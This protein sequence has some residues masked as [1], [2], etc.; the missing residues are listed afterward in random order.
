MST[1]SGLFAGLESFGWEYVVVRT[2]VTEVVGF[3]K[4]LSVPRNKDCW[5]F[6]D[7]D[8]KLA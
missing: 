5:N 8:D 6:E 3:L 7:F 1:G 4:V 2:Y